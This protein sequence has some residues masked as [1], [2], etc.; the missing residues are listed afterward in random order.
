MYHE[1]LLTVDKG[2]AINVIYLNIC[3]A[4]DMV[5]CYVYISKL[6]RDGYHRWS[7]QWNRNWLDSYIQRVL[8]SDSMFRGTWC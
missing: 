2:G 6:E 1:N 8:V 5:P 4:F 3:K 7:H